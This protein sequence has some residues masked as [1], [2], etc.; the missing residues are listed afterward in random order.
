[1]RTTLDIPDALFRQAKVKA[2]LE[3]VT[4]MTSYV[5]AGLKVPAHAASRQTGKRSKVPVIK[6]RGRV[7]IPHLTPEMQARLQEEADIAK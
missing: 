6:R 2:A 1:M 7:L 5:A 3:G 4:L